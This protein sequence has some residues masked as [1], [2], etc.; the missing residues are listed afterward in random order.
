M[1]CQYVCKKLKS[2]GTQPIIL[3][4]GEFPA[5][6]Q[7]GLTLHEQSPRLVFVTPDET[8][9]AKDLYSVWWRR[10]SGAYRDAELNL[11]D[12]YISSESEALTSSLPEY[13]QHARWISDPQATRMAGRKVVQLQIAKETGFRIPES[14][15]GNNVTAV[16]EFASA[17]DGKPMI[18]KALSNG[19]IRL[20]PASK[21]PAH[22]NRVVYTQLVT[23]DML[24][25][26]RNHISN[27]PFT[28]QE[29]VE[30]DADIRTT[31]VG[32]NVF[33][34]A[35]TAEIK[36][37]E[38]KVIDWRRMN[39]DRKYE[40]HELP[41]DITRQCIELT[42]RLDLT[43]GCIDLAF[44]EKEGY[45]FFEINPQGQWLVSEQVLGYP[46]ADTLVEMLIS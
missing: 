24:K 45:T 29:S 14:V 8:L 10:P 3:N 22:N 28:L 19:F 27:C 9:Y 34:M 6:L 32:D 7:I 35:I 2:H 18:L 33:S 39:T 42:K 41:P 13:M 38:T 4:L 23:K 37:D 15:F 31:V 17:M 36:G 16:E 26:K 40:R 46:I 30:K 5:S 44:S 21:D 20:N 43:F 12:R 11:Q 1:H 25:E